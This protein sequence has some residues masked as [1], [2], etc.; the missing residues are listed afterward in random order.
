MFVNEWNNLQ[1]DQICEKYPNYKMRIETFVTNA[2]QMN[3]CLTRLFTP[4]A[5]SE[6]K[7]YKFLV[8]CIANHQSL[9]VGML[10]S[11]L[12]QGEYLVVAFALSKYNMEYIAVTHQIISEIVKNR[13]WKDIEVDHLYNVKSIVANLNARPNSDPLKTVIEKFE[14]IGKQKN[15]SEY[16]KHENILKIRPNFFDD[17]TFVNL[18][19]HPNNYTTMQGDF[20]FFNGTK[21]EY[22]I[23]LNEVLQ[24]ILK[25]NL[26]NWRK[27]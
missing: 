2:T 6:G 27:S 8:G 21:F 26:Q 23:R 5:G 4:R 19:S 9:L 1:L 10:N 13:G 20:P 17:Y 18:L 7:V 14:S 3:D 22:L 11:L 25:D 12:Y 24:K 16:V 15:I